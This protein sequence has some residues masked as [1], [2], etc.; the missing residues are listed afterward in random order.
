M[1]A[2]T[3]TVG[4][5][6]L[7]IPYHLDREYTYYIPQ[8]LCLQPCAGAFVLVP[9]GYANKKHTALIT[10]V[11]ETDDYGKL[12]PILSLINEQLALTEEMM[13]LI[14]FTVDRTLCTFGDAV[15]RLIPADAFARADEY[16]TAKEPHELPAEPEKK[17]NER[18]ARLFAYIA[19]HSSVRAE[20]IEKE[21]GA[22]IRPCLRGLLA[23]GY[24]TVDTVIKEAAG[25]SEEIAAVIPNADASILMKPRTPEAQKE[26]YARM[27]E[28]ERIAVKELIA[29][30]YKIAQIKALCKK[31]L[32][33]LEKKEV[34]RN[35]YADFSA[36][37]KELRLTE[38]QQKAYE[39]LAALAE[40]DAP[41]AA[42]LH[43]VT[44]SGKTSVILALC[45]KVIA[46]GRKAIVLIPEIALTWQSVS[47]FT[48]KFG[49]RIAVMHSGLSDGERF[50]AYKRIRRGDIDIVLGT[51]SAVF[52]PLSDI[53]LIV[54]DEEQETAYKSD[55]S[56]KY[57]ARDI[58][59]HRA[60]AHNALLVMASATPSVETY[61][62]AV[63][64][65][66]TLVTLSQRYTGAALP[67]VRIADMRS[68]A[69]EGEAQLGKELRTLLC[70]TF[71]SGKQSMLFLNRRGFH[72][73]LSC[74]AC[75]EVVLCPNCSVS[76]TH[77][78]TQKGNRL[79]C[80]YCGHSIPI[81]HFC[82][83][84]ASEHLGFG[85]YGTQLIE[86]EIKSFLP[87]ARVI[88]MDA[89]TTKERFSQDAI[90]GAFSRGE[91]DILVGTQMIAKGHNFPKLSLV[92]VVA[93]DNSLFLDDFR[94]NER[95]FSLI[96]QVIGRA[97]RSEGGGIAVVQTYNPDNETIRLSSLQD[98]Q[99]FYKN[100]IA[101][102]KALVFPPFCDIAV[103]SLGA[104]EESE[105]RT[106]SA[107]FASALSERQ[108]TAYADVKML[109]YGPFEA[110]VFKIKNKFRMR[111]VVKF[112]NNKR[113]RALFEELLREYSK[114]AGG[115]ISLSV[116][117][118]PSST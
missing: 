27:A 107:E 86:E 24:I 77:H 40:D 67:S 34:I 78:K 89:D 87:D 7:D 61:R 108:K 43:G 113:A 97:G 94:A 30:G 74:H 57:H 95:T 53:G 75:G 88:R 100:E 115:K 79:I 93:A 118:N 64:G 82:P 111:L 91:A 54:I 44:G 36:E 8:T 45:E 11:G 92:G 68:A 101:V 55:M 49:E 96:T 66:Y 63:S 69:P 47:A 117:I 102:R 83:K 23:D 18:S 85:G 38:E 114:K 99:A 60:A 1:E 15:R 112:K 2:Y 35:H 5:R 46:S 50:D 90:T 65:K 71:E 80:H 48:S 39:T 13:A 33:S 59:K 32:I 51:R 98:Y 19:S 73:M 110:P 4:V 58:A 104:D 9:F 72:S 22:D 62:E 14:R 41:H 84:C 28:A 105:L 21:F 26:I 29:D 3:K 42:L 37:R 116:D 103:F 31:G 20:R 106:F 56:P 70:E 25:A 76:L 17:L 52:V 109:V 81:P 12:K 16:Y 6:L 10:S